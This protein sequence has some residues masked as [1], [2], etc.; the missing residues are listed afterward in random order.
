MSK[1]KILCSTDFSPSSDLA[2]EHAG[3]YA[4]AA[5]AVLIIVHVQEEISTSAGEGMLHS[6]VRPDNPQTLTRRLEGIV[7]DSGIEYE[8]RLLRG[9]PA[10]EIIRLATD[11][12]VSLIVMGTQG[13]TGVGR[14]LMGSVAEEVLRRAPCPVLTVKL[15]R[16]D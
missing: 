15:P 11:E 4:R 9:K 5:G 8:H 12:G 6:G 10:D 16:H 14:L 13:R 1:P 2:L 7:P 3:I